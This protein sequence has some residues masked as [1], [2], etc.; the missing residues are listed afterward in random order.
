M[1]VL[2]ALSSSTFI[3]LVLWKPPPAI[4]SAPH[5]SGEL[6]W[7]ATMT[8]GL[9]WLS[10]EA[11]RKADWPKLNFRRQGRPFFFKWVSGWLYV[12]VSVS[13]GV[14]DKFVT[15]DCLAFAGF[16][17]LE[18][19]GIHWGSLNLRM[20]FRSQLHIRLCWTRLFEVITI[21]Y[22][23]ALQERYFTV[24]VH[25]TLKLETWILPCMNN[26]TST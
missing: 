10:C 12:R 21:D 9:L 15:T 22:C 14:E 11:W 1:Y 24:H 19:G 3:L 23:V 5:P 26:I 20:V 7:Q 25:V 13:V 8:E 17:P 18:Y 6:Q 4:S 16:L 2:T